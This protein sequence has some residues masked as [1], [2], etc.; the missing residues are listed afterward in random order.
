MTQSMFPFVRMA[1][2]GYLF[3]Q[4]SNGLNKRGSFTSIQKTCKAVCKDNEMPKNISLMASVITKKSHNC[5]F[6]SY[7][8]EEIK[9]VVSAYWKQRGKW[10]T[11]TLSLCEKMSIF[12]NLVIVHQQACFCTCTTA[13]R[14]FSVILFKNVS[15]LAKVL[16]LVQSPY[17]MPNNL[18]FLLF[19][20]FYYHLVW[21]GFDLIL[22]AILLTT[23]SLFFFWDFFETLFISQINV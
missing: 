7:T 3:C 14:Y 8:F 5:D 4:W 11:S 21:L 19:I 6:K 10:F 17:T 9:L 13:Y 15:W 16:F 22:R 12:F 20:T 2:F 23:L 18:Q 1:K